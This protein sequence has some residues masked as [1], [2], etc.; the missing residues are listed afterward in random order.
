ME[1]YYLRTPASG[2]TTYIKYKTEGRILEIGFRS[3]E[4]YDYLDVSLQLWESYYHEVSEGGSSGKFFN[5]H[6][7]DKFEFYKH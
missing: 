2:T 6:I 5:E 1:H 7:K 3:L 4:V